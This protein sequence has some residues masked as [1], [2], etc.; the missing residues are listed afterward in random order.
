[1]KVVRECYKELGYFE[2]MDDIQIIIDANDPSPEVESEESSWNFFRRK[3]P[4][5]SKS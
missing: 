1:L 5:P 3:A 4:A 2:L